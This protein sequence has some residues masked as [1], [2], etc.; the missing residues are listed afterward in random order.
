MLDLVREMLL[1]ATV[2]ADAV[3]SPQRHGRVRHAGQPVPARDPE[4]DGAPD[5]AFYYLGAIL[6][7]TWAGR[8]LLTV[9]GLSLPALRV[10]GG[11]VLLLAAVP[12]VTQYQRGDA[13]KEAQLEAGAA[14]SGSWAQLVAVPLTFPISI[15]GATVAA[16]I[17]ATGGSAR[18]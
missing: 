12:M 9:L 1:L 5:R 11:F 8:P 18:A 16:V 3:Q 7:V 15:G 17:A 14:K 10:A 13:R 4:A 2:A 6:V